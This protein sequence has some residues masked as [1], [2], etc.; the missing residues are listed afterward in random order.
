MVVDD[1][2][3]RFISTCPFCA[4]SSAAPSRTAMLSESLSL[5]CTSCTCSPSTEC[6]KTNSKTSLASLISSSIKS[7]NIVFEVS[8]GL[9]VIFPEIL[10]KSLSSAELPLV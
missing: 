2:F 8:P 9:K 6:V 5:T 3:E 1:G 7:M 10:L 4:D